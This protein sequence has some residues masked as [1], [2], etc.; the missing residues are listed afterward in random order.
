MKINYKNIVG[1]LVPEA[2]F[3]SCIHCCFSDDRNC[4]PYSVWPCHETIFEKDQDFIF[5]I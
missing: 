2:Q 1:K 4:I 5:K 3:E